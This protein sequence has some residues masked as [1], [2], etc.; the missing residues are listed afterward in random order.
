VCW[1]KDDPTIL[2]QNPTLC[3]TPKDRIDAFKEFLEKIFKTPRGQSIVIFNRTSQNEAFNRVKLVYLDK[4][5]D[6]WKSFTARHAIAV[7]YY[8]KEYTYVLFEIREICSQPFALEN[9]LNICMIE[10]ERSKQNQLNVEKIHQHNKMRSEKYA[11]ECKE[12]GGF[13][14]SQK[15]V[16]YKMKAQEKLRKNEFYPSFAS[17]IVDFDVTIRCS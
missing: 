3:H 11:S 2:L 5:I 15:L 4:K 10:N 16:P 13:D 1:T 6:Y 7:I 9:L 17:L 8:N 14:F 12:L